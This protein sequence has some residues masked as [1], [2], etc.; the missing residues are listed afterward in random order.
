MLIIVI[1]S[2]TTNYINLTIRSTCIAAVLPHV[3]SH[4]C[5]VEV[6]HIPVLWNIGM[7]SAATYETVR[8]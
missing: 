5:A 7:P 6:L 8:N 1:A 3:S 4:V 2:Y